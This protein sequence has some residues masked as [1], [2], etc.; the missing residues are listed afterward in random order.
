MPVETGPAFD[1][2]VGDGSQIF[3]PVI[4]Q[5]DYAPG[6]IENKLQTES[7]TPSLNALERV[8]LSV[9]LV[10]PAAL[11]TMGTSLGILEKDDMKNFIGSVSPTALDFYKHNESGL[12]LVGDIAGALLPG[13]L[14]VKAVQGGNY[15]YRAF[16]IAKNPLVD[17]LFTNGARVRKLES[18][19]KAR[20]I[21]LAKKGVVDNL[22]KID[23]IRAGT[24]RALKVEKAL[25][26][27]KKGLAF[28]LGAY[29]AM[30]DSEVLYP[31]DADVV[32]YAI[33]GGAGI[34][35]PGAVEYAIARR[36]IRNSAQ[37]VAP[38]AHAARNPLGLPLD[39][40][41]FRP[42]QR[43]IGATVYSVA[44]KS[45][46]S[47]A[48]EVAG[49]DVVAQQQMNAWANELDGRLYNKDNGIVQKM[50]GDGVPDLIPAAKISPSAIETVRTATTAEPLTLWGV[51]SFDNVKSTKELQELTDNQI[52]LI[53]EYTMQRDEYARR[54]EIHRKRLNKLKDPERITEAERLH[55]KNIDL[56]NERQAQIKNLEDNELFVLTPKG[57]QIPAK[58]YRQRYT[59]VPGRAKLKTQTRTPVENGKYVIENISDPNIGGAPQTIAI[60]DQFNLLHPDTKDFSDFRNYIRS[61]FNVL[62]DKA[63]DT[64]LRNNLG[65]VQIALGENEHW[66]KHSL[67]QD[68]ISRNPKAIDDIAFPES[69]RANPLKHLEEA[70][71]R[72]KYKDYR[73]IQ[74]ENAGKII[75]DSVRRNYEDTRFLLDMPASRFG[76]PSALEKFFLALHVEN[77]DEIPRAIFE[78]EN[79]K[80][81]LSANHHIPDEL[82]FRDDT[83]PVHGENIRVAKGKVENQNVFLPAVLMAKRAEIGVAPPTLQNIYDGALALRM[84][85]MQALDDRSAPLVRSVANTI[86]GSGAWHAAKDVTS[87]NE[88]GVASMGVLATQRFSTREIRA[89]EGAHQIETAVEKITREATDKLYNR[90]N[91]VTGTSHLAVANELRKPSNSGSL[92][93]LSE[94]YHARLHN[95]DLLAEP[96][97]D[98]DGFSFILNHENKFNQERF[99]KLYGEDLRAGMR[100]PRSRNDGM[101]EPLVLDELSFAGATS[102]RDLGRGIL[103]E[104]NAIFRAIGMPRGINVKEWWVPPQN[105]ARKEI[106]YLIAPLENGG[107]IKNMISGHTAGDLQRK[108]QSKEVQDAIKQNGYMLV[109][110]QNMERYF[111]AQDQ[112]FF[113][114]VDA[115]DP[116]Q[117]VG[118]VAK[119]S[120]ASPLPAEGR[121]ILDAAF[122]AINTQVNSIAKRA[123]AV[124]M[125]PQLTYAKLT[126]HATKGPKIGDDIYTRYSDTLVGNRAIARQ[127]NWFAQTYL[128]TESFADDVLAASWEKLQGIKHSRPYLKQI[129]DQIPE[130]ATRPVDAT[131]EYLGK[132]F[133]MKTPPSL[134]GIL[135]KL[136]YVTATLTLRMFELGHPILNL[137]GTAA[138]MPGVMLALRRRPGEAVDA[139]HNR[140]GLFGTPVGG[141]EL[142]VLNPA[143]LMSSASAYGFTKE[144]AEHWDYAASHGFL[145]QE[146][147]EIQRTL[148]APQETFASSMLRKG[149][150]IAS[151]FS[152]KSEEMSRGWAH[153]G[154]V[155]LAKNAGLSDPRDVHNFANTFASG[156]IGDYRSVNRPQVFQGAIGMPLGLFQTFIWNYHQK[157]FS[158]VENAQ[159]RSLGVA[160]ASQASI[161]GLGAVPG[162]HQFQQVFSSAQDGRINPVDALNN[163]LGPRLA[164][165]ILYGS[166]SNIPQLWGD[167]GIALYSRGDVNITRLPAFVDPRNSPVFNL[168]N[169]VGE[170]VGNTVDMFMGDGQ[171]SWQR[172][173]EILGTYNVSRPIGRA[174]EIAS[175]YAMDKRGNVIN[176]DTRSGLSIAARVLG[177]RPIIESKQQETWYRMRQTEFSQRAKRENMRDSLQSAIRGGEVDQEKL[178]DAFTGYLEQGGKPHNF[179]QFIRDAALMAHTPKAAAKMEQVLKS[180]RMYDVMRLYNAYIAEDE[181]P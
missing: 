114:L 47:K 147:A 156:V 181:T 138:A 107:T 72:G 163:R 149:I 57:E 31:T 106:A 20:D 94:Y 127:S 8:M 151:Y 60:D 68:L 88:A 16:N 119:G 67:V 36:F 42:H 102:L 167:E 65:K 101:Y 21:A 64:H 79:F 61:A 135:S 170:L 125:E 157:M 86:V 13:G 126:H 9:G 66:F 81:L 104:Q 176:D 74:H 90:P 38:V 83:I 144:G 73:K 105:F 159:W 2:A 43:D 173:M 148:N 123:T 160:F 27:F 111:L 131:V 25:D 77:H 137:T 82:N 85:T 80:S 6:S 37:S 15:V 139:W 109:T 75:T 46:R 71:V 35:L 146:V 130:D 33:W 3:N 96:V 32:D 143:K 116:V 115:S 63:I 161:F 23:P 165:G 69:W 110:Q 29:A 168:F 122:R 40:T 141:N 153:M 34:V 169:N 154:G 112:A 28:E 5:F 142:A 39:E 19:L 78:G 49:D 55:K 145:A 45:A 91:S 93:K 113:N 11:D 70:I 129:A 99:K 92:G 117:Q 174:F 134:A 171:F 124:V 52:K 133:G 44:S 30:N 108:I 158:Y 121:E 177:L 1:V 89:M 18:A 97:N 152:D 98:G 76:E 4:P 140:L 17:R 26:G 12:K 178:I 136:N 100:M 7:A 128:R 56:F 164:D 103:P 41:I 14:A 150:D 51:R 58:L 50:A 59:D 10:A 120:A 132:T 53:G 179:P 87:L 162:F 84:D 166:F 180:G 54:I 172:M 22:M 155:I 95:W 118:R 24:A 48:T 62:G 175:G